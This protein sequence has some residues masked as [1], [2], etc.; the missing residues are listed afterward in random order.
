MEWRLRLPQLKGKRIVSIYFGGG[1]PTKLTPSSYQRLI[2]EI[3]QEI[4]FIP[5]CEVTLEANPEDITLANMQAYRQAGINRVSIGV[6]SLEEEELIR[7]GRTHTA[8]RAVQAILETYEAGITNLSIDLM[9]ELPFQTVH[10]WQKTLQALSLLPITH[11]SLY[12]LT[13][14]PHTAFFK[15]R[16]KLEKALASEEEKKE[17]LEQAVVSLEGMGLARYEI[18][19]FAKQGFHSHH[20]SGYWLARPFLGFG[21]SAF[22]YWDKERFSNET[23]FQHYLKA[24][25]EKRFP[26]SFRERLDHFQHLKELL[27]VQLRLTCGIDLNEF[28][29]FHGSL[30]EET[31]QIIGKLIE[32]G[33]LQKKGKRLCLS[34]EGQLF[35]DSIAV[36]LI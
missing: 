23:N 25:Q 16:K 2:H 10:S 13:I 15:Q 30:L 21:P 7:L 31:H 27:V 35:Y 28:C 20:N 24:V 22:S 26:V 12:N 3:S 1:T 18:S 6:Q 14:E 33:W 32:R 11:L 5:S 34:R 8:H 19:A 4:D 9:F 36:E 29:A 17:M